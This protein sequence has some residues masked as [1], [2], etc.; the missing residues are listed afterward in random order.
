METIY[1]GIEPG[2]EIVD[3]N[4]H[5]VGSVHEVL[6]N[7]SDQLQMLTVQKGLIF[8]TDVGIPAASIDRMEGGKIHLCVEKGTLVEMLKP[9]MARNPAEAT[10]PAVRE[11]SGEGDML[12]D[13]AQDR[14]PTTGMPQA[15]M[16]H[17]V[18]TGD[19][20]HDV[21]M[22]TAGAPGIDAANPAMVTET[23]THVPTESQDPTSK[24]RT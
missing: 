15:G 23:E 24:D 16:V 8:K 4:G 14:N 11:A 7:A 13:A 19:R 6:L 22:G 10:E 12:Q 5:K 9:D 18:G 20:T 1:K 2:T 3:I 17:D 21:G